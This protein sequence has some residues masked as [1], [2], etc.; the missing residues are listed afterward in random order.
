MQLLRARH[1]YH[2]LLVFPDD[3]HETLLYKRW[4]AAFDR[5]DQFLARFLKPQGA[6]STQN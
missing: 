3:T 5:M 6:R 2:E 1:V 4:M